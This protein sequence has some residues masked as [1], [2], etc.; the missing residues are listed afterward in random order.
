MTQQHRLASI[1]FIFAAAALPLM[2]QENW[3]TDHGWHSNDMVSHSEVREQHLAVATENVV[4]PE[5]NG[6]IRV[7]GWA[8]S[9]ILVKACVQASAHDSGTAESLAKQVTVTDGP[10]RVVAK[11][12]TAQNESWW[13]VSYE[14]WVPASANLELHAHNG[15]IHVEGT[16]GQIRAHAVNGSVKLKDVSGDVEGETTNGS[17]TIELASGQAA[18]QGKGLKLKTV[19]GS[20]DLDLPAN[21]GAEVEVSTVN[22]RVKSEFPT[23]LDPKEHHDVRFTLGAGGPKIEAQTVNGSVH[24][25]RQS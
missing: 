11:G 21:F 18:W 2:A 7:H 14:I 19:N 8:N 17:L 15:S 3:C 4:N 16:L 12:P 13:S 9:D 24:I 1:L 10:G 23:G 25:G 5:Q 6:S 22:G 20:I